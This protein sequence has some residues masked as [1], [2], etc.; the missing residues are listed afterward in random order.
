[1]CKIQ[2]LTLWCSDIKK[3][4]WG[5]TEYIRQWGNQ[6]GYNVNEYR[7]HYYDS[8]R[9]LCRVREK[10]V[11]DTVYQYDNSNW[12]I[13]YQKGLGNGTSCATP[14]GTAKVS[15]N[16]DAVGR[17]TKRDFAHSGTPDILISYDANGNVLTTNRGGVN[18]TYTYN[19]INL[20]TLERLNVDGR[21]Y[22]LGHSYNLS[23]HKTQTLMPSGRAVA[24]NVDGLGRPRQANWGLTYYAN[25]V[26]YHPSGQVEKFN[27]GNGHYFTQ[28]LDS[29]LLPSRLYTYKGSTKAIDLR[30][31]YDKR[32][33][34]TSVVDYAQSNNNRTM[35]YDAIEQ[36]ETASGPWGSGYFEYDSLGNIRK[37]D[38]GARKV[39]V[40][41]SN[42]RVSNSIDTGGWGGNTGTR[43]FSHDSR[44]NVTRAGG[45]NFAY[46]YADQP[47]S[48]SGSESGQYRYDA[49]LKRVKS[50]VGGK[51]IYNVYDSAG[52]LVHIDNV[53][54]NKKTDYISIGQMTVARVENNVPTY[55][56][57]DSLGSPV[58]GTNAS[59]TVL[60]RERYT[61]YGVTLDNAGANDDQAG[62]T[63]H[64][65]DSDTGL[66]YMQARYYDPV[67]GRF[68][69]NDPIGFRDVHS[70]NRYAYANNNPYKYTD[71]DGENA[72]AVARASFRIGQSV[73][74]GINVATQLVTGAS[75]STHIANAVFDIVH[76]ESTPDLPTDIVGDQSDPRAGPNKSGNKHTSGTLTPE[77]GGSGDFEADLGTV[78]G[79]TRPA[80]AGDKAPPGSLIGENGAFGRPEN[81]SG[82]ASIDIPANGD[83]PHETLHYDKK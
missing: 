5:E 2:D 62:Y 81:S 53:T 50:T 8:K 34:V 1:L 65:K 44:G 78:A 38:L 47:T 54:S 77:N 51:T 46:D 61:P 36:V 66:V 19:K 24:F 63:G 35:T 57:N 17:I 26:T 37:K 56:H 21:A 45:I 41:Y 79:E 13:A 31:V 82:G 12:L 20:P 10:D 67:I 4:V 69:S 83:K 40:N 60:W 55:L 39:T 16:R 68:Y 49:N 71:P 52:K 42:N 15:L 64:I 76:N 18:W 25:N 32:K 70:F 74:N 14:S 30:Y 11:G 23:G 72:V 27:F 80:V 59:G 22:Q 43:T 75:L 29:R 7:Y 33:L 9:R 3:N 28:T 48:I 6:N 58:T 73:G